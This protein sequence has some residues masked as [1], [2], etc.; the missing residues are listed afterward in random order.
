MAVRGFYH[1]FQALH[2]TLRAIDDSIPPGLPPH[3]LEPA[4]IARFF[5]FPLEGFN[6]QGS[7]GEDG[8]LARLARIESKLEKVSTPPKKQ[9]NLDYY[10]VQGAATSTG[11]SESHIRRAVRAGELPASNL[12]SSLR[13]AWRIAR[14]DLADWMEKKKGGHGVPPKSKLKE[15]MQRHLPDLFEAA[16]P[17]LLGVRRLPA[18]FV[19]RPGGRIVWW[20]GNQYGPQALAILLS[21]S[22][23][24]LWL[25]RCGVS[26]TGRVA[27]LRRLAG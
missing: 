15:L 2:E 26:C 12:G 19:V 25:G 4:T 18:P 16:E 7:Q 10:S 14:K 24:R 20:F 8:V 3:L 13:P 21:S 23:W 9:G 1:L 27:R 5:R 22:P 17:Q 11:L 6:W